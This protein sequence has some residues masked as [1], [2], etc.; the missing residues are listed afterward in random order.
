MAACGE[1]GNHKLE[2][3]FTVNLTFLDHLEDLI[4]VIDTPIKKQLLPIS[5][6]SFQINS[7][8]LQAP[9]TLQ[10]YIKQFQEHNK[11]LHLQKQN[12]NTHCK[13]KTFISSFIADT[14][15][16]NAAL[17]TILTM[18]VIIYIVTGYSK[19][20]MLVAN[21]ALQCIKTVEAES[22][23]PH[24]AICKKWSCKNPEFNQSDPNGT[25]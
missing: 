6:E 18:L 21:M 1:K 15:G 3:F 23:N 17:L 24:Y 8:L 16:F 25:C 4:E 20:K 10:D 5:L 19:L 12:D 13:F 22:L 2:M 7:S 11:K 14:I 9:K